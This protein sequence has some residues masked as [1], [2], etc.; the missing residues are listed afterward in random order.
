M[1]FPWVGDSETSI[2][3]D[4]EE[5]S[6]SSGTTDGST[7]GG[8]GGGG[9]YYDWVCTNWFPSQ[10]PIEGVQERVCAN[11]GTCTAT[12][13]M[14]NETRACEFTGLTEPLFDIF[15]TISEDKKNVCSGESIEAEITLKNFGKTEQLDGFM[16][17]WILNENNKLISELKDTR[18]IE[19]ELVYD[20]SLALPNMENGTYRFYSEILYDGNK[21]ALA[22]DTFFVEECGSFSKSFSGFIE[23]HWYLGVGAIS[24][25]I[26]IILIWFITKRIH[27]KRLERIKLMGRGRY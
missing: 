11:R 16:A 18:S 24:V 20:I 22:A 12:T 21:T 1:S 2:F 26:L 23:G 5:E 19:K 13:G 25:I 7:G 15:V 3:A 10:C 9:C 14:P 4:Y 6:G 8:G 27:E 17:Y